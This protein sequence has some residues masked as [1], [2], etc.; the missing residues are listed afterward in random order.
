MQPVDWNEKNDHR[1]L[2][3]GR[4]Q[5]RK[6]A[7]GDQRKLRSK[8]NRRIEWLLAGLVTSVLAAASYSLF[9]PPAMLIDRSIVTHGHGFENNGSNENQVIRRYNLTVGARWLNLGAPLPIELH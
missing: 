2:L 1:L 9:W 6:S 8:I 5:V 4:D 3:S 7:L